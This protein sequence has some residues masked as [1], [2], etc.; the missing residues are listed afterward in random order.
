MVAAV[1]LHGDGPLEGTVTDG[2]FD[3]VGCGLLDAFG[4]LV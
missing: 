4:S 3:V 2:Q 1:L